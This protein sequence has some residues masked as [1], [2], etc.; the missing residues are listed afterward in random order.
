MTISAASGN[1]VYGNPAQ[2]T[3]TGKHPDGTP[4]VGKPFVCLMASYDAPNQW[5]AFEETS[6][7]NGQAHFD[8]TPFAQPPGSKYG[9]PDNATATFMGQFDGDGDTTP[10]GTKRSQKFGL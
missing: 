9:S 10:P 8:L 3:M 1:Y 6:D 2:I 4:I 5:D 7:E